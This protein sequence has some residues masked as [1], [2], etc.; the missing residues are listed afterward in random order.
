MILLSLLNKEERVIDV[1]IGIWV[2][3]LRERGGGGVK[4]IAKERK[5]ESM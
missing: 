3:R 2:E 5:G 1:E 4:E